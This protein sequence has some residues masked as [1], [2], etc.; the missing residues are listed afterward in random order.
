MARGHTLR[1]SD[2]PRRRRH[3]EHPD[4]SPGR[5]STNDNE[6]GFRESVQ[7]QQWRA[8]LHEFYQPFPI[9]E[10]FAQI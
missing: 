5:R 7:Y 8:L 9:G 10:H 3:R 4:G 2:N 6:I 1:E